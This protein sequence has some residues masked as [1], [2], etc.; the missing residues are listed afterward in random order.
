[1]LSKDIP[2]ESI[3]SQTVLKALDV[4][5]CVANADQPLSASQ[6]AKLCKTSRPTAYRLLSTLV[7]RG[8]VATVD[9]ARFRLGTQALSLSKKVLASID[10]P[11][12][13]RPYM[14]QLSDLTN[15]TVNLSIREGTE[16][17]Y[18]ARVESSQSIRMMS[19]I[20]TR[21]HMHST[22][23]GK[24]LLAFL[25]DEEQS[26]LIGRLT[27]TPCTAATITDQA[28]FVKELANIRKQGFAIDNEENEPGVRCVGAP[29]F[30]HMGYA[31]A[32]ISISGPAYRISA[33][34]LKAL[35]RPLI[36][37]THAISAHL[38]H[39]PG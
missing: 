25:P 27:L 34:Q 39:V 28:L 3:L 17:L 8:Y 12:V 18:I 14:R 9:G 4:L 26:Q 23:M 16:I 15:E 32:A 5:E 10:L 13:A 37:A 29:I 31:F 11:E 36:E 19:T 22:A 6:V 35:A 20:G 7:S 1:M 2:N 30:D 33:A 38:G 21:S 24:A